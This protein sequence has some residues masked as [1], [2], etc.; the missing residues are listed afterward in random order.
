M[1]EQIAQYLSYCPRNK[2]VFAQRIDS[3]LK[4]LDVGFELASLIKDDLSSPHLPMIAEDEL[5]RIIRNSI[6]QDDI[7]GDYIALSNWGILFETDLKLNLVSLFDSYSK[8]QTLILVNCGE[9]VSEIFH[10]VSKH[11]NTRLPLEQLTPYIIR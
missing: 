8:N 9:I 3:H 2:L 11:F 6:Q 5:N 10:L 1:R 4:T 7:I